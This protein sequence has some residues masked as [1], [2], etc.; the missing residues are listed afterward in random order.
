M[1]ICI[2]VLGGH[3]CGTSAVAGVLHHLGV[4]MG[5]RLLGAG[6]YNERGHWE[7]R[8]FLERHKDIVGGVPKWKSPKV[9]FEPYRQAYSQL[10]RR[11]EETHELWGFK[12]PRTI[13]VFSHFLEV[14]K[15]EVRVINVW[16]D[17]EASAQS[18]WKRRGKRATSHINVDLEEA[19]EIAKRYRMRHTQVLEM[20]EGECLDIR[21]ERLCQRPGREVKGI[22]AFVGMP[23]RKKAI[24]FISPKLRHF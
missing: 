18:M 14:A 2:V 17:L 11:R 15:C 24:R 10:V 23:P 19:R 9:N 1:S 6:K 16:R 12:D 13:F 21:Y 20:W 22:A 7:D 8:T 3:R 5:Y 4:F